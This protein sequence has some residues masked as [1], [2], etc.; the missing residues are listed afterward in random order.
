M[1]PFVRDFKRREQKCKV[2]RVQQQLLHIFTRKVIS[3]G[4]AGRHMG[5]SLTNRL[6]DSSEG[7]DCL[8]DFENYSSFLA[9]AYRRGVRAG[10]CRM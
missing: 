6:I 8:A 4:Y 9:G 7:Q 1:P 2:L 5:L 3:N 10:T